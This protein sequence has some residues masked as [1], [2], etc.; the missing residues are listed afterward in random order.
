MEEKGI[1]ILLKE[2]EEL[3]KEIRNIHDKRITMF[4]IMLS[5]FLSLLAYIFAGVIIYIRSKGG[6]DY[7]IPLSI[8]YCYSAL[9]IIFTVA[10]YLI[11]F[12][13]WAHL[14]SSKKHTIRYWKAIHTIRLG[15]KTL[16]KKI[17]EYLTLPDTLEKPLRPEVSK[18]WV[19]GMYFY[20]MFNMMFAILVAFLII[21][22]FSK[23][24]GDKGFILSRSENPELIKAAILVWPFLIAALAG[25]AGEMRRYWENIQLARLIRPNNMF[26]RK[27]LN[28]Y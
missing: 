21:P 8:A 25:G 5:M 24:D 15:F 11:L 12:G 3:F 7:Q 14:G 17:G 20:P 16:N 22:L 6:I 4:K 9:G 13:M 2:Y 28:V 1:D 10:I 26:P 19:M 27:E 18:K 23:I